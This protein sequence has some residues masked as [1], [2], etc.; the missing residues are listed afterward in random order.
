V[1]VLSALLGVDL[2]VCAWAWMHG[3]LGYVGS[4]SH[5]WAALAVG[6]VSAIVGLGLMVILGV[7]LVFPTQ[8]D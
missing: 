2:V 7:V 1:K 6:I 5:E 4:E 8:R 3:F